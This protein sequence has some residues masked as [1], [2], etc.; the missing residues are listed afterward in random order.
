MSRIGIIGVGHL[1]QDL[2]AGWMRNPEERPEIV[3][4][5]RN[6]SKAAGLARDYGLTIA[7]SNAEVVANT[8]IVILA[9]RPAQAAGAVDGL[10]W[11]ADQQLVSVCAGVTIDDLKAARPAV[12]H[13]A[14]PLTASRIGESPTLLYPDSPV[15]R[16]A[17]KSLGPVIALP[18][19]PSFDLATVNAAVYGWVFA[20]IAEV[21]DYTISEGLD[22]AVARHITTHSF[23]AATGMILKHPGQPISDMI[24]DLA[25]P[26][27]ITEQGLSHLVSEDALK[28]WGRASEQVVQRLLRRT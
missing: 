19:E 3:L 6:A 23:R 20:L 1:A 22:P 7:A 16:H 10:P 14:M 11:R 13:R 5:P 27:G 4:S 9:S 12:C 18:D 24:D 25:T 28:A 17:L 8:D 21:T 26:G 2:V 15:L